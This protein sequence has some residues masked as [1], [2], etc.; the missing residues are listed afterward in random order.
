MGH[1]PNQPILESR[2]YQ[3]HWVNLHRW[4]SSPRSSNLAFYKKNKEYSVKFSYAA[5]HTPRAVK[6]A[7]CKGESQS[8]HQTGTDF[9][10]DLWKIK[11]LPKIKLFLW[12]V[13]TSYLPRMLALYNRK[14]APTPLC[15]L[16]WEFPESVE[17]VLFLCPWTIGVWFAS[18]LNY[19]IL[20][21]TTFDEWFIAL[22]SAAGHNS[23]N[24]SW[25]YTTTS[26]ICWEIWKTRCNYNFNRLDPSP[27]I[28]TVKASRVAWEF[29]TVTSNHADT[30]LA[31]P[32]ATTS[33][34]TSWIP[35][36]PGWYYQS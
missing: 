27:E 33:H 12:R 5:R 11:T 35:P 10:K 1:F 20:S 7:I 30:G 19:D 25:V 24:Q 22:K 28:T 21:I 31:L 4:W 6:L 26:F 14:V 2:W 16:C 8:S 13:A 29:L 36:S 9:W 15:P 3:E 32:W 18:S 23:D 17:H 34:Q